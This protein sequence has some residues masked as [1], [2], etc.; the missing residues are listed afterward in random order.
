MI[1]VTSDLHIG[2]EAIIGYCNRP[3]KDVDDMTE[4]LVAR[5]NETVGPKDHV[6]VLGDAVMGNREKNL[7]HIGR[8][9]GTKV[10]IPGNHDYVHP[11]RDQMDKWGP[12]YR[13]VFADIWPTEMVVSLEGTIVRLC[14]FPYE[15]DHTAEPRYNQ[16]E[17][18]KYIPKDDGMPLIHGHTHGEN[19]VKNKKQIDIGV[20]AWDYRPVPLWDLLPL[21]E[22]M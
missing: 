6:W 8:L 13:Q 3:F 5:W 19:P 18:D 9:N 17:I 1:Y 22:A 14:H 2:H 15:G 4:G 21:I 7:K 12:L 20:D 10:L 11:L 16:A